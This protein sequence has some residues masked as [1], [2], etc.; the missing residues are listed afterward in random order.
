MF[1]GNKYKEFATFLAEKK[2]REYRSPELPRIPKSFYC[3][4]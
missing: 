2:V 4:V 1:L 3:T